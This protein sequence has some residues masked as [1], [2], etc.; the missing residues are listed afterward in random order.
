MGS[1]STSR[2]GDHAGAAAEGGNGRSVCW[3]ILR[4]LLAL[5]DVALSHGFLDVADVVS[6]F[7]GTHWADAV[8]TGRGAPAELL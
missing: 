6:A 7:R 8:V 4:G 3:R 1:D 5:D 2:P